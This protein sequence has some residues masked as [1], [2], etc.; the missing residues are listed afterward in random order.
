M[1]Q[2]LS[3]PR[4]VPVLVRE[5]VDWLAPRSGGRYLDATVGLGGHSAAL[6]EA[7]GGAVEIL[8][9]DR[10]DQALAVARQRLAPWAGQVHLVQA[11][12]AEAAKVVQEQGWDGVDGILADLGVSSLQLET[13]ERGFSF[14][15]DGPLDMRM[16]RRLPETAAK[17]VNEASYV[18]L[19]GI[20][21]DF[22]EEPL[23]GRIARVLVDARTRQPITST[24]ELARLVA[25]AYPPTRRHQARNHPAT[26]T[27]QALRMAVNEELPAVEA[28]LRAA[29]ALLRP[30]ARL[31]VIAFHS[32]EDRLV[33]RFFRAEA[34]ACVC[35]PR[36]AVC[37]C[38][39]SPRLRILTRKPVTPSD[40]EVAANPRSRSAKLRAAERL[41]A[42]PQEV[43]T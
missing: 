43:Q 13:P 24:L 25:L 5:V 9:M 38:G 27:F 32:L 8:G 41:P 11:N 29:V 4:H 18:R 34:A 1:S 37:T 31:V 36:Q 14:A 26:R 30:G 15:V 23:A 17:L 22:G 10:D 3:P 7:T 33:K 19:K 39:H 20:I 2:E 42:P 16:D 6:L 12:F 21:R 35:P 28:L 40:A